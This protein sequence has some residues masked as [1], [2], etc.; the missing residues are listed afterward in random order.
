MLTSQGQATRWA[1]EEFGHAELGDQRRVQ[2]L[3]RI[4]SGAVLQPH[5]RVTGTFSESAEL[6]ATYR[7]LRNREFRGQAITEASRRASVF[8][9]A[10]YSMVFVPVDGTSLN[11]VDTLRSKGTG[12]VGARFVGARGLQVMSSIVVA[13]S[14]TPLGIGDQIYWP[15]VGRKR[16]GGKQGG[17]RDRRDLA[18][19]ETRYWVESIANVEREFAKLAPSTMPWFQMDRGA[20]SWEVLGAAHDRGTL[21]TVRACWDRR[22]WTEDHEQRRYLR[23]F[24]QTQ[25]VQMMMDLHVPNR[26]QRRQRTARLAVRYS[27]VDLDLHNQRGKQR[28]RVSMWAVWVRE[29]R[30][31]PRGEQPIDWLLL[32]THPVQSTTDATLVI[33]GYA[34]RW[35][36]EEFHRTWKSGACHVEQMQ[37]RAF[38]HMV[39]WAA[40]LAAVAIR[41]QRLIKLSRTEPDLP[42]TVELTR[43]EVDAIIVSTRHRKMTAKRGDA[44]TIAEAVKWIGA[45]GGHSPSPSAGPPGPQTLMRG[46]QRLEALAHYLDEESDRKKK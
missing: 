27:K 19:R 8:R 16:P 45:Y 46:L 24:M 36:I 22:L 20:D 34:T 18:H 4:A 15:R 6:E 29:I 44:M 28:R 43:G 37:L 10:E 2:R 32:T 30:T 12:V 39:R 40:T 7:F 3:V 11:I 41:I 21:M 23:E 1:E 13:P 33:H 25:P 26:Q 14:G 5:G 42:A 38:D 9:A 31:T 17:K 35:S